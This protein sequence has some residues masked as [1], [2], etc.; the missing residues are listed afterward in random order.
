MVLD[1]Q[2]RILDGRGRL[3]ACERA[4]AE[5]DFITFDG[6]DPH[7]Y[8]LSVNLRR[9]SLPKGQAAMITIKAVPSRNKTAISHRNKPGVPYRNNPASHWPSWDATAPPCSTPPPS[10]TGHQRSQAVPWPS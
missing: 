2:G 8:V 3:T 4:G 7:V 5:P 10:W 9:C 6:A 1:R